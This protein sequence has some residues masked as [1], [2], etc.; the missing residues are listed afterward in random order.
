[1]D[2]TMELDSLQNIL[3]ALLYSILML[4]LENSYYPS[5]LQIK[6]LW[7]EDLGEL[8]KAI[9]PESM[10]TQQSSLHHRGRGCYDSQTLGRRKIDLSLGVQKH[11]PR[12]TT[13]PLSEGATQRVYFINCRFNLISAL[14]PGVA[15]IPRSLIA[16]SSAR[17]V[18]T[19]WMH[20]F[21][22]NIFQLKLGISI[23]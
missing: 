21:F 18:N 14:F 13:C 10:Q 23:V 5:I 6:K 22:V 8:S 16:G 11:V 1:M 9:L 7:Q 19:I 2:T 12:Q 17:R 3:H 20:L 15:L 4:T